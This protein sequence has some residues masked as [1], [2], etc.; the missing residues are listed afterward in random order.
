M[1]YF[2]FSDS[3]K[4]AMFDVI[5]SKFYNSN[6]GSLSKS[7]FELLMF[8]FYIK[9]MIE[10]NKNSDGTIDYNKCSDYKISKELGITQQRVR[11]LKI[12]NHLV[13]PIH[14]DWE[15]ALATLTRNARLD[16]NTKKVMLNIPDP[17]LYLEIQNFIEESGAYIEKQLNGKILQIRV[18]YY[19]NLIL[20]SE[21]E[22]SRKEII[23]KL[24]KDF[25][26]TE[27]EKFFDEKNIGKT[28]IGFSADILSVI[29]SISTIISPTNHI[30]NAIIELI[31]SAK[32]R[33][34]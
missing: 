10:S 26:K 6:F 24:K 11:N 3:E 17:N 20:N 28:L 1:K 32:T 18:E 4:I 9:K 25:S 7:D 23:K 14:F 21:E 31:R 5:S 27:E 13:N 19:V 16:K 22:S 12:K 33:E 2:D 15:K 29:S 34:P 8:N 30:A